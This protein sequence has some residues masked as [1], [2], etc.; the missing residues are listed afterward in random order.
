MHL[1]DVNVLVALALPSHVH[2][3]M[4]HQWLARTERFA[5]TPV[6]ES[7]FVRLALNPAVV[8][9]R[10]TC[11]DVLQSL[12]GIAQH[13]RATFFPDDASFRDPLIDLVGM[14]SQGRVTDL[15]LVDL[16][17]KHGA[18]LVTFDRGLGSALVP[19]DRRHLVVLC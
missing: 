13:D 6:T 14:A 5:L 11:A 9:M 10:L 18:Q 4:A 7:G 17:A 12:S 3:D 15:H 8:G 1:P 19:D 16:A 2:H